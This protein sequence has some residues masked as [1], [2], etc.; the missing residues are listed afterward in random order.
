VGAPVADRVDIVVDAKH[1]DAM[2]TDGDPHPTVAGQL[3]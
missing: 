2:V 3:I 1:C